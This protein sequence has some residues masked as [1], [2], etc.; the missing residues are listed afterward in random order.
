MVFVSPQFKQFTIFLP[1]V[2]QVAI[3]ETIP[4]FQLCSANN[5]CCSTSTSLHTEQ[6]LPWVNPLLLQVGAI[7][8]S[9]TAV[10]L[11][12]SIIW[13]SLINPHSEHI[14]W[15]KPVLLQVG[16]VVLLIKVC[17]CCLL[18]TAYNV[19]F[20]FVEKLELGE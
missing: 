19:I 5:S 10:W 6:W 12:L 16:S 3:S 1:F 20:E 9:T 13:L 8:L 7:A 17:I 11:V 14:V 15:D 18:H 2:T 4:S